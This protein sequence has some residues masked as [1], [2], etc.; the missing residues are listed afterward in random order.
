ML[1][2]DTVVSMFSG[3]S[4]IVAEATLDASPVEYSDRML[5]DE[6]GNTPFVLTP[7]LEELDVMSWK[8]ILECEDNAED[9]S[10]VASLSCEELLIE[11]VGISSEVETLEISE[12]LISLFEVLLSTADVDKVTSLE[13]DWSL[14]VIPSLDEVIISLLLSITL[15][16][17]EVRSSLE[18]LLSMS[19]EEGTISD[20]EGT[21]GVRI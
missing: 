1:P 17:E 6:L 9:R 10:V 19:E 5:E 21:G 2:P 3:S 8:E 7:S 20:E 13:E 12:E 11:A 15:E 4:E 14:L 16:S 18:E